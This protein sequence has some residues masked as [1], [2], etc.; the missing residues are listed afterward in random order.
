MKV[1]TRSILSLSVL[2]LLGWSASTV[3]APARV[4][5]L[6]AKTVRFADLDLTT[7]VGAQTLYGR[8]RTAARIVCRDQPQS[9]GL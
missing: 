4:G 6:P 3:A 1:S 5:D 7:A 8:I 2:L 9:A